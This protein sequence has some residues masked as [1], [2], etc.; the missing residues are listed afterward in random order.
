VTVSPFLPLAV[1]VLLSAIFLVAGF[2][3][4]VDLR[5][6]V[7]ALREFGVPRV[8]EPLGL[9]L[10]PVELGVAGGLLFTRTAEYAA[11]GALTLLAVFITGIGINLARG[12]QPDCHC[13]GQVRVRPISMWTLG[14]NVVL[15]AAAA[16]L[17]FVQRQQA[18][19]LWTFLAGLDSRGRRIAA[20]VAALIVFAMLSALKRE[21]ETDET[22]SAP[23]DAR[24]V[25]PRARPHATAV[26]AAQPAP[27]PADAAPARVLTGMGLP[28]GTPAPPFV[29]FDSEGRPH[30]LD[31]LRAAGRPVVLLFSNPH[32]RACQ[33]LSTKLPALAAQY[34]STL[35]M[36]VITREATE[37]HAGQAD[38]GPLLLFQHDSEVS[39]AY[40]CEAIPAAVLIG[41]DGL[42]RSGLA[43][44]A[45]EIESL[46]SS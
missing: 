37:P 9:V 32:C 41:A 11:W 27:S 16:W 34:A 15:A 5:G 26:A 45:P 3:K 23:V 30:S 24:P 29:L 8:L 22:A 4:L 25:P 21:E 7:Q 28:V 43:V 13:F 35:T 38:A 17:V 33:A 6:S 18:I 19:D 12:R 39:Q 10:P 42:I 2:A 14:R 46:L 40:D 44:G 36:A 20:V 1:R 31:D